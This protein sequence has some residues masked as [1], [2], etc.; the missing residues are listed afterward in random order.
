NRKKRQEQERKRMNREK[1]IKEGKWNK[2]VEIVNGQERWKFDDG[3]M[4]II[5]EES[6]RKGMVEKVHL[7]LEHRGSGAVYYE[8]KRNYYW[9]GMRETVKNVIKKCAKCI[10]FNRKNNGGSEF[11]CTSR[12]ME[13]VA[14]DLIDLRAEGKYISVGVDYYTRIVKAGVLGDIRTNSV[15]KVVSEWLDKWKCIKELITD[16]G[17]EFCS[18]KFREMCENKG[19]KHDKVGV[20]SHRSN[21]RVKRV[22]GTIK[23]GM[24]KCEENN[25]KKK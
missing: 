23:E 9:P 7:E 10:E 25:L 8:L 4:A 19:I 3:S 18:E 2:H 13:K 20:E 16:N 24:I 6:A 1:R 21:G 22:I 17:K 14:L 5:S 15:V 11:V 12:A